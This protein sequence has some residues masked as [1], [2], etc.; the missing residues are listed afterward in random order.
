[1]AYIC[2]VYGVALVLNVYRPALGLAATFGVVG[3]WVDSNGSC[4]ALGR[5]SLLRGKI[6]LAFLGTCSLMS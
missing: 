2:V 3:D 6:L 4:L 5:E 1:M